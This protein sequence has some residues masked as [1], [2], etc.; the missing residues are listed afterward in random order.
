MEISDSQGANEHAEVEVLFARRLI[1]WQRRCG[2]HGLPWQGGRDP[3]RIWLSEI[4]LQQTQVTTVL[5]YYGRFLQAFPDVQALARAHEDEVMALW[6][7]LGYYSRAR[8]LHRCAQD[9]VAHHGGCFPRSAAELQQLPGIGPST[10]AAIAAFA[11]GERVSI[12]DANV[13]RVLCR[14]L[15]MADDLSQVAALRRLA[16][17]AAALL[18]AAPVCPADMQAYTQ[19]LMDLGAMI[20]TPRNPVCTQCPMESCCVAHA[21][22]CETAYPVRSRRLRRTAETWWLLVAESAA[23][24][25]LEKRPSTGIWAGLY[26]VPVFAAE[27]DAREYAKAQ[28]GVTVEGALEAFPSFRHVLTH[29]D[30]YLQPLCLQVDAS[31]ASGTSDAERQAGWRSDWQSLGLP[32]PVRKWLQ[33]REHPVLWTESRKD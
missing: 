27:Q 9:I 23:G 11:F 14:V 10:A 33:E 4:M 30:L 2:R 24:I 32:A 18:P 7:G 8:N 26:C 20:C 3:Y 22:H 31:A 25:W 6:S 21:L 28:W 29:K 19:G 12:L 1:E 17:R 13:Q 5:G 16:G 15:G